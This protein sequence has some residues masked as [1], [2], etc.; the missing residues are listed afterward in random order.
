MSTKNLKAT[1]GLTVFCSVLALTPSMASPPEKHQY[2]QM[3][4][5]ST[6]ALLQQDGQI[7][8]GFEQDSDTERMLCNLQPCPDLPTR[9][10]CRW[11][12]YYEAYL[13]N[14]CKKEQLEAYWPTAE[15]GPRPTDWPD[16]VDCELCR[17][18]IFL[19]GDLSDAAEN[20]I[21]VP[22]DDLSAGPPWDNDIIDSIF[23]AN[24][25]VAMVD[26]VHD[27]SGAGDPPG[28]EGVNEE[29][30]EEQGGGKD[31][32]GFNIGYSYIRFFPDNNPTDNEDSS[33]IWIGFDLA[34]YVSADNKDNVGPDNNLLF[35]PGNDIVPPTAP[36]P[37]D[38][39][40]NGSAALPDY[41]IRTSEVDVPLPEHDD[42]ATESYIVSLQACE[43]L[44]TFNPRSWV[45]FQTSPSLVFK[46]SIDEPFCTPLSQVDNTPDG[47]S[48]LTFPTSDGILN[49]RNSCID[50]E[51]SLCSDA[52]GDNEGNKNNV[53]F[54]I[55]RVETEGYFGPKVAPDSE[56]ARAMR[57]ALARMIARLEPRCDGDGS[58]EESANVAVFTPIP[59]LEVRKEIGCVVP[60]EPTAYGEHAEALPGSPIE[61]RITIKNTGNVLQ[62]VTLQDILQ[63]FGD[64]AP[65]VELNPVCN[66]LEAKLTS[67]SRGLV[68]YVVD[69]DNANSP[70]I[71]PNIASDECLNPNFFQETCSLPIGD[72][73]LESIA[74]DGFPVVLGGLLGAEFSDP[75]ACSTDGLL[76]G[77]TLVLTYRATV[78][79]PDPT[80]FC[81]T[82]VST[83]GLNT[84]VATGTDIL[85]TITEATDVEGSNSINVLCRG[86]TLEKTVKLDEAGQVFVSTLGIETPFDTPTKTIIYRYDLD[87]TSGETDEAVTLTDEHLCEDINAIAGVSIPAGGDPRGICDSNGIIHVVVPKET[88]SPYELKVK[89]DD[90]AAFRLF[91]E[92]D[93]LRANCTAGNSAN[94]K[95]KRYKNCAN[96]TANATN[97]DNICDGAGPLTGES[98]AEIREST[99]DINVEKRVRCVDG[100]TT[101]PVGLSGWYDDS[102]DAIPGS[103][104]QF[105][106]EVTNS[107]DKPIYFL[108]FVDLMVPPTD[109]QF[110]PGSVKLELNG[111]PFTC[112][113]FQNAFNV[114]TNDTVMDLVSCTGSTFDP[115]DVLSVRFCAE[116]PA[117]ADPSNTLPP[118]PF[119]DVVN[120]ITVEADCDDVQDFDPVVSDEDDVAI[121]ILPVD[122]ECQG[123]TWEYQVDEDCDGV[124]DEAYTTPAS[125]IDLTGLIFPVQLRMCIT[126][127]NTG[128]VPLEVTATDTD[129]IADIGTIADI[130]LH[131]C[132]LTTPKLVL[133]NFT[134]TWCCEVEIKTAEAMRDLAKL[135][136]IDDL[137]YNNTATVEGTPVS[138]GLDICIPPNADK[139]DDT[140]SATIIAPDE[141]QLTITKQVACATTN[142]QYGSHAEGVPGSTFTFR[143]EVTNTSANAKFAGLRVHDTLACMGWYNDTSAKVFLRGADVTGD[144]GF[145][146]V[147]AGYTF[148]F[149]N[150]SSGDP[151]MNP[152][153]SLVITF[154]IVV[155]ADT[156]TS[157]TNKAQAFAQVDCGGLVDGCGT[158]QVEA[159][160]NI[161]RPDVS[162][163]KKVCLD[164]DTNG[165]C[166]DEYPFSSDTAADADGIEFP[167]Y[168]I[169]QYGARNTGEVDLAEVTVCDGQILDDAQAAGLSVVSCDLDANGC[170]AFGDISTHGVSTNG[171][172]TLKVPDLAA[173]RALTLLDLDGSSDCYQ[174]RAE[175]TA[176]TAPQDNVCGGDPF[177]VAPSM[178]YSLLCMGNPCNRCCP[179]LTKAKIL[180]WNENE[181]KFSG[182]EK[183]ICSHDE[184]LISNYTD[185]NIG[186]SFLRIHLQTDKGKGRI[187]NMP[188][189]VVCPADEYGQ[190]S[191]E[192][193]LL[194]IMSQILEFHDVGHTDRTGAALIA[195]GAQPGHVYYTPGGAPPQYTPLA[196]DDNGSG[197]PTLHRA[198]ASK[199]G[200]LLA[201]LKVQ[202]R[203]DA[204]MNIIE[205]T[206]VSLVNDYNEPVGVQLYLVSSETCKFVDNAFTLTGNQPYYWSAA[207][208]QMIDG[209]TGQPIGI[210]SPLSVLEEDTV[211]SDDLPDNPNGF[212]RHG[213][214]LVWA[215]DQVTNEE[216]HWNHLS[217]SATVVNYQAGG[218]WRYPAWA[219]AA[220]DEVEVPGQIL[221]HP[222]GELDLDGVE[223]DNPPS[224]L[225]FDFF[226]A[227][228]TFNFSALD[229]PRNISTDTEL[230]LWVAEKDLRNESDHVDEQ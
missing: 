171:T 74:N 182:T 115:E 12:P 102:M 25:A 46:I 16:A 62:T 208:G 218:A 15:F 27:A 130:I 118:P 222:L 3:Y 146:P 29:P 54:V 10:Y 103:F 28:P 45:P 97:I 177:P 53:E 112:T 108:K 9:D 110:K 149:K 20:T 226:A 55:K 170:L 47:V 210:V 82:H 68:D 174:N 169:Y 207:T 64:Q 143:I 189:Q 164:I 176:M 90:E 131:S 105:E 18:G 194:G 121:D 126:A 77:D 59:S 5:D 217:G 43:N 111:T 78:D 114:I 157:C 216:V 125:S 107:G 139:P 22:M 37:F 63:K 142:P 84:I 153:D 141:C 113:A 211:C 67:P 224:Q 81:E 51:V 104:V 213:Y 140:C 155:P 227:G 200:S 44:S 39:G 179:P 215:V 48:A 119:F 99:C 185:Y 230:I 161:L 21:P 206:F 61:F 144:L 23:I 150:V 31:P 92:R 86:I 178:C 26:V 147:P 204:Q 203:Y 32:N 98:A 71:C 133:P 38:A 91:L 41:Y 76:E 35:G 116:I 137:I 128:Q 93:D 183:C 34:D 151:W 219:F 195:A 184:S 209:H 30:R 75:L 94:A 159:Q 138:G 181:V 193:P 175:V 11:R 172:C 14:E 199:K 202:A 69:K 89:F 129:F 60:G 57:F 120:Q 66:F 197:D 72:S 188:S 7:L 163:V 123:K 50:N 49:P 136:G 154:D 187:Y 85:G 145:S 13:A 201:F 19:D 229:P 158:A 95:K 2:S 1:F 83:D 152:G 70:P 42:T 33:F 96:I 173:W 167:L 180:I 228:A 56:G 221:H 79:V 58:D 192:A 65:F 109:I 36:V 24:P 6:A 52:N 166:D 100:C 135:D 127:K 117:T 17:R 212:I 196:P 186:N 165:E 223:Y 191:I 220:V 124:W 122:L 225:V 88:S 80:D 168:I 73:F 8:A 162:C 4:E 40:D 87:N 156:Y 101:N 198:S 148:E 160:V 106:I 190:E 205:D 132:E 134:A 214:L